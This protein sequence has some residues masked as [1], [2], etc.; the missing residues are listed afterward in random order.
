MKK[1]RFT[2]QQIVAILKEVEI[3][4]LYF[5]LVQNSKEATEEGSG[6]QYTKIH[7]DRSIAFM[8]G[9]LGEKNWPAAWATPLQCAIRSTDPA[10]PLSRIAFPDERPRLSGKIAVPLFGIQGSA[11][12]R[13][14]QRPR[15]AASHQGLLRDNWQE[16]GH[17]IR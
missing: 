14:Q 2:E 11:S 6:A 12:G 17:G 7:V 4:A 8:H 9:Y 5:W 13:F 15:L 10:T 3:G 16:V 1:S